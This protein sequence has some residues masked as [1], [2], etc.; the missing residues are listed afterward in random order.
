MPTLAALQP[1][2]SIR[3]GNGQPAGGGTFNTS[4]AGQSLGARVPSSGTAPFAISVQN[5]G[6]A[7]DSYLVSAAGPAVAGYTISYSQNGTDITSQVE[8][9]T[10]STPTLAPGESL[11]IDVRVSVANPAS[12]AKVKRVVT[13]TSQGD[14]S[15]QDAVSFVVRHR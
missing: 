7:P 14:P 1:D 4:A 10:F 13:L 15:K 12:A 6:D 8:G 3:H 9:G 11:V 5:A 2:G